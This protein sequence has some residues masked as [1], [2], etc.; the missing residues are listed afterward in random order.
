MACQFC[1]VGGG[2]S[3]ARACKGQSN[4]VLCFVFQNVRNETDL[5]F[6]QPP[7]EQLEQ[8]DELQR[9]QQQQP[10]DSDYQGPLYTSPPAYPS[11]WGEGLG[12]WGAAYA[13]ARDFVSQLTLLE[14]VNL[15][16]GVG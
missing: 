16:T 8:L 15:T 12:D 7:S 4:R 6:K 1:G 5:G 13:K 11:P 9:R 3:P 10:Y 14:K 2:G